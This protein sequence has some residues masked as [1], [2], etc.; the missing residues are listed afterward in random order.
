MSELVEQVFKE[1]KALRKLSPVTPDGIQKYAPRLC[2]QFGGPDAAQVVLERL[3]IEADAYG[4]PTDY[5][6][7]LDAGLDLHGYEDSSIDV[8]ERLERVALVISPD[9]DVR[10]PMTARRHLDRALHRL[11][12]ELVSQTR[13]FGVEGSLELVGPDTWHLI[14]KFT[15]LNLDHS[16]AGATLIIDGKV[17]Q[18]EFQ[19]APFATTEPNEM[20]D[21]WES[22]KLFE[23]ERDVRF[24]HRLELRAGCGHD[25]GISADRLNVVT[26][27]GDLTTSTHWGKR[28]LVMRWARG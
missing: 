26:K 10:D 7:I 22:M 24:R 4:D 15:F 13:E 9:H 21:V 14:V 2:D 23:V 18:L 17:E 1:L 19:P 11:A 25:Q 8:Q 16:K 5:A 27:G 3:R 6:K 12:A 20:A 28:Y